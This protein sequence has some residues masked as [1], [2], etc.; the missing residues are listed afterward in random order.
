MRGMRGG[1]ALALALGVVTT[2]HAQPTDPPAGDPAPAPSNAPGTA[3]PSDPDN[4][5]GSDDTATADEMRDVLSESH[6]RAV[7]DSN[8]EPATGIVRAGAYHDS[9]QTTVLRTIGVLGKTYGQWVLGGSFTVDAV[10][11]ASVDV[12]SSPGL[13]TVDTVTS[14]SGRSSTS[15]GQMTDTRYQLTGSG[16]WKDSAGHSVTLSTAAATETDYSS[17]S[18]GVNGSY[19]ILDR[20]TTLLGGISATDNWVSSVLDLALHRKM[21]AGAWSAGVAR[22]LTRDDAVRV[23]Y[24]GKLSSGDLAS[25]YR[26]VRFGNWTAVLG[27]QQITFSNTI[28]SA[29]GLPERVPERRVSHAAVVEWVHSLAL[30]VGLHTEVRAAHDSWA[31][32]SLTSSVELRLARPSWRLL[33]GYRFYMQSRASFFSDK[34]TMDPSTYTYYTS[35]KELGSENGH[36][37][38]VDLSKVVI[39]AESSS[40]TKM[41]LD[42]EVDA[43]HYNY[44]GFVLLPSRD[45]VF[46]MAGI[47]WEL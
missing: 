1:L 12:R 42:L 39:D 47:R 21:A 41:L 2:A 25:P 32:N 17:I 29:D 15:G 22:V 38:R 18:V 11:S 3:P 33:A 27:M 43:V 44:P 6:P 4:L 28:G 36:L 16:G 9:D 37:V 14:A 31:I 5:P 8:E 7:S 26:N 13:S 34:Y 19:D 40:D 46:V 35:D 10:T 20:T 23:R 45:S 30:G 24:D